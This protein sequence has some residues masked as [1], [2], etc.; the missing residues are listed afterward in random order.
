M[1]KTPN[2]SGIFPVA[3]NHG[4]RSRLSGNKQLRMRTNFI[5]SLDN[6]VFVMFPWPSSSHLY[7]ILVNYSDCVLCLAVKDVLRGQLCVTMMNHIPGF[8][9]WVIWVSFVLLLVCNAVRVS[10]PN[11]LLRNNR[12][13]L[14]SV[15]NTSCFREHIVLISASILQLASIYIIVAKR[16]VGSPAPLRK[17]SFLSPA[18]GYK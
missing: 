6:L 9:W 5:K 3:I 14:D 2:E 15:Q 11:Q 7:F 12:F 17:H 16:I 13:Q 10:V 1:L 8:F 18:Q 4:R